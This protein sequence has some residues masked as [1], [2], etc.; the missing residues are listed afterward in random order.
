MR[1]S[2][3]SKT[4]ST[5]LRRVCSSRRALAIWP[6]YHCSSIVLA[7]LPRPR[8][9]SAADG[10]CRSRRNLALQRRKNRRHTD[11]TDA[12]RRPVHQAG[13][14]YDHLHRHRADVRIPAV[15]RVVAVVAED[16]HVPLGTAH[17]AE[18]LQNRT[19]DVRFL[20]GHAVQI[21]LMA[22]NLNHVAGQPDDALDELALRI[23][24][25]VEDDDFAPLRRPQAIRNLI[26][27]QPLAV[28]QRRFHGAAVHEER[29]R[30]EGDNQSRQDDGEQQRLDVLADLRLQRAPSPV[31]ARQGAAPPSGAALFNPSSATDAVPQIVQLRA[32]H[33]TPPDHFDLF[34]QRR[35]QREQA[36]DADA[37]G[38]LAHGERLA[39]AAAA[40]P[41]HDAFEDLDALAIALDDLNVHANRVAG[42]EIRQVGA[43]LLLLDGAN[44]V[45][46]RSL[47]AATCSLRAS[48]DRA[49]LPRAPTADNYCAVSPRAAR[50]SASMRRSSSESGAF[51]SKSGRRSSVRFRAS[52]RR[53]RRI[54]S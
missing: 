1:A 19:V 4:T 8:A 49:I 54:S 10:A 39:H 16:E 28:R 44:D 36:L 35:M 9:R 40:A 21:Q 29:L 23:R 31:V 52:R 18:R 50:S 26:H 51:S 41:H 6:G 32:A 33:P 15:V 3:T 43:H 5:S 45:H 38:N 14:A 46:F 11:D 30:D 34:D 20:D 53:Q 12:A 7:S 42:L 48:W 25:V 24:G 17:G 13:Y 27:Q 22:A 37:G 2:I 47:L